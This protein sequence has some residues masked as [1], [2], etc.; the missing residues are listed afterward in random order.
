M[1][2]FDLELAIIGNVLTDFIP[3]DYFLANIRPKFFQHPETKYIIELMID[4]IQSNGKTD[5]IVLMDRI[6][7]ERRFNPEKMSDLLNKSMDKSES[8]Y[9]YEDH[10]NILKNHYLKNELE[11][12]LKHYLSTLSGDNDVVGMINDLTNQAIDLSKTNV[13]EG[14]SITKEYIKNF[15]EILHQ[16]VNKVSLN[17]KFTGYLSLDNVLG[18]CNYGELIV[19]AGRPG[20]GK[21]AFALNILHNLLREGEKISFFSIEMGHISIIERLLSIILS[22]DNY[23]IQKGNLDIKTEF[24][25]TLPIL[26]MIKDNIV[27]RDN[28]N[29]LEDIISN[30]VKDHFMYGIKNFFIDYLQ[31]VDTNQKNYNMNEKI[32]H[33][34]RSLAII[35][36]LY[37]INIYLLSQLN[38]QI[39]RREDKTPTLS[40]LRDSGSI[41]A[42]ASKIMFLYV[43]DKNFEQTNWNV[44]V[45]VAKNRKGD[46]GVSHF[47]FKRNLLQF[48]EVQN[49]I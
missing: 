15:T 14:L 6:R 19:I 10:F 35:S 32:G 47:L 2:T 25:E 1:K 27:I 46:I 11:R 23:R 5:V 12:L 43:K 26:E 29:V 24:M 49:G 16:R 31:L 17:T 7:S 18:V 44:Q 20:M 9:A 41:E 38:R 36:R 45:L 37:N 13:D 42:D 8:A 39:E 33:I 28:V 48:S 22:L 21:T 4:M 30:I 40:D 34:T 3:L